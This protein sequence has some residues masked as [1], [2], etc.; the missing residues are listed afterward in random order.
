MITLEDLPRLKAITL[1]TIKLAEKLNFKYLNSSAK[2]EIVFKSPSFDLIED[3]Y[4]NPD[5]IAII[6]Y[7]TSCSIEELIGLM[8][9]MYIGRDNDKFDAK[10]HNKLFIERYQGFKRDDKKEV[11]HQMIGKFTL[12]TNLKKGLV[13]LKL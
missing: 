10:D 7:L 11:I 8:T 12:S 2:D 9:V 4:D 1:E 13:L 6:E 5:R 3:M